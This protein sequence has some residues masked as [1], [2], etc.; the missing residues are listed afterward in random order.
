MNLINL[1]TEMVEIDHRKNLSHKEFVERYYNKNKPVVISDAMPQWKA[2][3]K[4]TPEFFIEHFGNTKVRVNNK[5]FLLKDFM[6][7]TM[8]SSEENPSPYLNE[9]NIKDTFPELLADLE[10]A[11][12]YAQPDRLQSHLL[13]KR[14]RHG[15]AELLIGGKGTKFPTLHYDGYHHHTFITQIRGDKLFLFY[16]PE[17]THLMYPVN[18]HSN[19]SRINDVFN[20]DLEKFPLFSMAKPL[21]TVLKEGETI[22]VPSGWWHTTRLLSLSIAVSTNSVNSVV[23]NRYVDDLVRERTNVFKREALRAYLKGTGVLM[24]LEERFA[25]R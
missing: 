1:Q 3:E 11:M 4:W 10:P 20:P 12:E 7:L 14:M 25:S 8:Q 23:W 2:R 5:E 15:I 19:R 22:F 9:A 17:Q 18:P 21:T 16:P 24:T 13:P 6:T